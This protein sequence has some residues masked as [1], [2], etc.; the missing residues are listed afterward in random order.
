MERVVNRDKDKLKKTIAIIVTSIWF[1]LIFIH[2]EH[3]LAA[4]AVWAIFLQ[5][6]QLI[7]TWVRRKKILSL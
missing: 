7:I 2:Q 5:N 6:L 4:T 1:V 3:V